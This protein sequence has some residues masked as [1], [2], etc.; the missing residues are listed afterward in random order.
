MP[1]GGTPSPAAPPSHRRESQSEAA[2]AEIEVKQR[3]R[4]SLAL[5]EK[6]TLESLKEKGRWSDRVDVKQSGLLESLDKR[7]VK[8]QEAMLEL[9]QTEETYCSDVE[10][11]LAL[12]LRPMQA[13]AHGGC[14]FGN[15]LS[16]R[17]ITNM[18]LTSDRLKEV[19]EGFIADLKARQ[20]EGAIVSTLS[21]ILLKWAANIRRAFIA[22]CTTCFNLQNIFEANDPDMSAILEKSRKSP[23]AKKLPVDAFVLAPMQRLARYPLLLK[24]ILERTQETGADHAAVQE[25]LNVYTQNAREANVRLKSLE[26]HATLQN[27]EKTLDFSRLRNHV[28]IV[29]PKRVLVKRGGLNFVTLNDKGRVAKAKRL[30]FM[31]FTDMLL[32]AKPV[33]DKRTGNPSYLVYRMV[34]RSL[35][36]A[37]RFDLPGTKGSEGE[38][39]I[40][41]IIYLGD[42][43]ARLILQASSPTDRQRWMDVLDPPKEEQYAEWDCPQVRVVQDYDARQPDEISLRAGDIINVTTK[44]D[45]MMWKGTIVRVVVQTNRPTTG[46]FPALCVKEIA[47]LHQQAKVFK[48]NFKHQMPLSSYK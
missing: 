5:Y 24:S 13:Q 21:D 17:Q 19:S 7:E 9:L 10:A 28:P 18:L 20:A 35:F 11:L 2:P 48:A 4:R 14:R 12:V 16:L 37:R 47:S 45:D 25:A 15:L 34:H 1:G 26:D 22:Y 8:R 44:G 42:S 36:E 29:D 40:E 41:M 39:L 23:L 31:L 32:Y 30:E 38:S 43:T 27:I 46:W 33:R 3:N 6:V